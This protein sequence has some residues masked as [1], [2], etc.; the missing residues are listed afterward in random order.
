MLQPLDT[1]FEPI[2]AIIGLGSNLSHD[3]ITPYE[4]LQSALSQLLVGG[5]QTKAVS[6]FYITPCFPA[7]AGADY[8]NAVALLSTELTA[9]QLLAHLHK[10]EHA[11][12]RERIERWGQRTLDLDLLAYGE[13]IAPDLAG[14]LHWRDLPLADQKTKAPQ[15]MILPHPRLQDRAF[16]LVPMNDVAPDWRHPVSQQSPGQMLANLDPDEIAKIVP[17]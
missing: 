2:S 1:N 8:V 9:P 7:G 13:Q 12:G 5:V 3:Q 17:L 15:Q 16:V 10:V 11:M 6:R 4:I 14:Y